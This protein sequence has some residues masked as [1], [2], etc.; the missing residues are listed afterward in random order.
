MTLAPIDLT[1]FNP[2]TLRDQPSPSL[3]WVPVADLRIDRRYQRDVTGPGRRAI[4]RIANGFDWRKFG[5]VMCAPIT[6]GGLA[7]VDGQHRAHAA[8][9]CGIE[10]IP[11]VIVPMTMAEQAAG[12]AAI[13]R[14][15]IAVDHNAVLR[16]E[17]AAGTPWAVQAA[18]AVRA[19]GCEI[20][21]YSRSSATRKP[22][23]V[24]APTLLRRMI[25][26]GEGEAV[27]AGLRAIRESTQG[28]DVQ[29]WMASVLTPWLTVVASNQRFLRLPLAAIFD[30][31]DWE[32]ERATAR[33]WTRL[34][35]GSPTPV[36]V[37]RITAILRESMAE[38][39]AA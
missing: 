36:L 35:G 26:A 6:G 29:M 32:A 39:D 9:L 15:K 25:E 37:N 18:E 5:A 7:L 30:E 8:A 21:T 28:A 16:A 19:A 27:T 23:M 2:A 14:D 13:N 22:G 3:Q 10:T 38:R 1:G 11:A 24:F 20:G 4:Q 33:A 17:L 34:N 12:F 31:V